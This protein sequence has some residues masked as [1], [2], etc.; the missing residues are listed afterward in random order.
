MVVDENGE[1][2][3]E[4]VEAEEKDDICPEMDVVD[5]TEEE[6][7]HTSPSTPVNQAVS[8]TVK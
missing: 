4:G 1:E 7:F 2:I 6:E 5:G 8:I 3:I